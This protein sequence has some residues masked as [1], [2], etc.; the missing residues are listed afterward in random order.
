MKFKLRLK[1][2]ALE[3]LFKEKCVHKCHESFGTSS[4][5]LCRPCCFT[6]KWPWIVC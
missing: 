4:R 6:L 3:T 1:S 5:S 2:A